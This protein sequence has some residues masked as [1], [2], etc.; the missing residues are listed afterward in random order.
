MLALASLLTTTLTF[1][2][3][4]PPPF[5]WPLRPQV[6][7]C[8]PVASQTNAQPPATS[9]F[10]NTAATRWSAIQF[11]YVVRQAADNGR[12]QEA[13]DMT[14][15]IEVCADA[16]GWPQPI[17][18]GSSKPGFVIWDEATNQGNKPVVANVKSFG[19]SGRPGEPELWTPVDW[20]DLSNKGVFLFIKVNG[21]ADF[22]ALHDGGYCPIGWRVQTVGTR[23][24]IHGA[25]SDTKNDISPWGNA[26]GDDVCNKGNKAN[27]LVLINTCTNTRTVE[28]LG[29]I[30]GVIDDWQNSLINAGPQPAGMIPSWSNGL[31]VYGD[32]TCKKAPQAVWCPKRPRLIPM[33]GGE[34]VSGGPFLPSQDRLPPGTNAEL[35]WNA[36]GMLRLAG[37]ELFHYMAGY[38]VLAPQ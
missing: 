34:A 33:G 8:V 26:H 10:G 16:K 24:S 13:I 29:K 15:R 27:P 2:Q 7:R 35:G 36:G 22:A 18:P 12:K 3:A 1:A 23:Y 19:E 20:G 4:P 5:A 28:F 11:A 21:E 9:G 14:K 37:H 30:V 17:C 32:D 38:Y 6:W 31:A 25:L